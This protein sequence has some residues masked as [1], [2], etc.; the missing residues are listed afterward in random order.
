[1]VASIFGPTV[2]EVSQVSLCR[3]KFRAKTDITLGF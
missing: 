2:T 3:L 1:M